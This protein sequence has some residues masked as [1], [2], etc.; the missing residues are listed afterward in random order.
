MQTHTLKAELLL[1][2]PVRRGAGPHG[3][4]VP[5]GLPVA[6]CHAVKLSDALLNLAEYKLPGI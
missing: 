4:G 3:H 5:L 6:G 1:V 2:L